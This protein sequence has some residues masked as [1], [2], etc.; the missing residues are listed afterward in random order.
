[1]KCT[2][3]NGFIQFNGNIVRAEL[4]L[5]KAKKEKNRGDLQKIRLQVISH[6]MDIM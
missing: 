4:I 2:P 1:M 3:L 5:G 6:T